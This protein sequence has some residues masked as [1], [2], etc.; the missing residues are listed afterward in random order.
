MGSDGPTRYIYS[1]V[2]SEA[3]SKVNQRLVPSG[4]L[5]EHLGTREVHCALRGR[6][7]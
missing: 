1:F 2:Q 4:I 7:W 3:F 6:T 5:Q